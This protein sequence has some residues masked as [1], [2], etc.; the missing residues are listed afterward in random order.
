MIL[1]AL[2]SLYVLM[3]DR[4]KQLANVA[5]GGSWSEELIHKGKV[6]AVLDV[7]RQA[8]RRCDEEDPR[9]PELTAT[10][11]YI[12]RHVEKGRMYRIGIE[13]ALS[14]QDPTQR[15]TEMLRYV[16]LIEAW[17]QPVKGT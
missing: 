2:C 17:I 14:L 5:F 11:V 13:K 7:L 15:Q 16:S 8:A 6:Q 12:E 4:K 10:L 1:D 9:G 3:A